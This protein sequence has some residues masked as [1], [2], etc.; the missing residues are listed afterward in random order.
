MY[1][2]YGSVIVNNCRMS[3]WMA[4]VMDLGLIQMEMFI[5]SSSALMEKVYFIQFAAFS[6]IPSFLTKK[7]KCH[8]YA[9]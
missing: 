1:I 9:I 7:V 3:I 2:F 6:Q 4:V 5:N 8:I